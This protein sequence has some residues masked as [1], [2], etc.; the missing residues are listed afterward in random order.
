[1]WVWFRLGGFLMTFLIMI[2]KLLIEYFK[3]VFKR[4]LPLFPKE[5]VLG[6]TPTVLEILVKAEVDAGFEFMTSMS[7][8]GA[9]VPAEKKNY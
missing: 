9:A 2:T 7:L 5:A 3:E 1:M 6:T 8:R 4:V